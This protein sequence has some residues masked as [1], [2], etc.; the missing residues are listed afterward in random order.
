MGKVV[1]KKATNNAPKKINQNGNFNGFKIM[2]SYTSLILGA[3]VVLI[4]G[5]LIVSFAKINKNRE[6]SS[7]MDSVSTENLED[8]NTS[9]T[10]TVMAGDD[11]WTIS[12]RFYN[13][14]YKWVEIAKL[15]KIENP[16]VIHVGNK[17]ILPTENPKEDVAINVTAPSTNTEITNKSITGNAYTVVKGD[18][19]WNIAV[20][21]YGDGF[22]WTEIAK[23]NH[24][25]NPSLIHPG[26]Y[27]IIPR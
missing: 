13:N 22:R 25:V 3:I 21:A 6:A 14:G 8:S 17:L 4:I 2:E 16:G 23:A 5:I 7:I 1:R 19:L 15:N 10:Y 18:C 26:N 20:R 9:S 27:F 24:L 12:Q 11:L